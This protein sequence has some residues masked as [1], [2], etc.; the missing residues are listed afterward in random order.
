MRRLARVPTLLL[1][2]AALAG[3]GVGEE[4]ASTPAGST[5]LNV[6]VARAKPEPVMLALS[7]SGAKRCDP[8]AMKRLIRELRDADDPAR[9]CTEQYGGPERAHV[10]GTLQGRA[11]DVTLTRTNGCGIAGY[12]ALFAAFGRPPLLAG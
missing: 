5:K 3:C 11:V 6:E 8:A 10:T 4:A 7:C 9:A 12:E 2:T 1:A